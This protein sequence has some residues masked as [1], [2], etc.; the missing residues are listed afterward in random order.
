MSEDMV[1][2]VC[3]ILSFVLGFLICDKIHHVL[4]SRKGKV[5]AECV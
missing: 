3:C 1:L 2:L 4:A 5:K